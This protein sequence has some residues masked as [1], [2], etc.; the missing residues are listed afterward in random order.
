MP[1]TAT[2]KMPKQHIGLMTFD[3]AISL[4]SLRGGPCAADDDDYTPPVY[5]VLCYR[6]LFAC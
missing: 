4:H 3:D 1:T 6:R 5:L 2:A